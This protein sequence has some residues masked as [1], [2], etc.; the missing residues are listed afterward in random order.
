M[1]LFPFWKEDRATAVVPTTNPLTSR[2]LVSLCSRITNDLSPCGGCVDDQ[3]IPEILD[4][5]AT[6][7]AREA[8]ER[9]L[10]LYAGLILVVVRHFERDE[11]ATSDCFVHICQQLIRDRFR[12]LRKFRPDGPARFSTW[13][14][15]VVRNLCLDWHRKEFGR[16]RPFNAIKRA[17]ALDQQIFAKIYGEELPP[18]EALHSLLPLF[19]SLNSEAI[20]ASVERVEELLTPRQRWLLAVRRTQILPLDGA[21]GEACGTM[22]VPD[23]GLGPEAGVLEKERQ[24]MLAHAV[25]QLPPGDQVLLDLRFGQELTLEQIARVEGLESAQ[26]ADRR[27]RDVVA[28]LRLALNTGM[29]KK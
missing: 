29:A 25:G 17:S 18:E 16:H 1:S 11:D 12:R 20:A 23:P 19:P 2:T 28:R 4:S 5:L 26:T 7:Q 27:I 9:F 22:E 13:L 6:R 15:A 14:R 24:Q 3:S 10:R 8:W 21:S